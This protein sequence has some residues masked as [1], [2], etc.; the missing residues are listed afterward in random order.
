LAGYRLRKAR[1]KVKNLQEVLH[2]YLDEA[3]YEQVWNEGSALPL[4]KAV[5]LA[6]EDL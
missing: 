2:S 4:Q 5:V 6:L 3:K 1:E